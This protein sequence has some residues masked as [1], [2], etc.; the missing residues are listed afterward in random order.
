MDENIA[1]NEKQATRIISD[2]VGLAVIAPGLT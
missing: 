1:Q 2:V